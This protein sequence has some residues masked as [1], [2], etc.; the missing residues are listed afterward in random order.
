M[1]GAQRRPAGARPAPRTDLDAEYDRSRRKGDVRVVLRGSGKVLHMG[2]K[3]FAGTG[4]DFSHDSAVYGRPSRRADALPCAHRGV[5][6]HGSMSTNLDDSRRTAV[7]QRKPAS[8]P[9]G[10][11]SP[12]C[13]PPPSPPSGKEIPP[14]SNRP[15]T[16]GLRGKVG[17][18]RARHPG[19]PSESVIPQ[20]PQAPAGGGCATRLLEPDEMEKAVVCSSAPENRNRTQVRAVIL[21]GSGEWKRRACRR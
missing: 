10:H 14:E 4:A 15:P 20:R 12:M 11:R 1:S 2:E 21:Q 3:G 18:E 8:A 19:V 9:S 6:A 5:C 13:E 17:R 16:R 7:F